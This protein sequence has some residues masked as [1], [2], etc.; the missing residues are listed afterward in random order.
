MQAR[1]ISKLQKLSSDNEAMKVNVDGST[2]QRGGNVA[3]ELC[4]EVKQHQQNG[5]I[6]EWTEKVHMDTCSSED[7]MIE[8]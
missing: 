6:Y 4:G 1:L 3:I 8:E 2:D 5:P 7:N